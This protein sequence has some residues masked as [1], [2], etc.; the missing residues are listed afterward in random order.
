MRMCMHACTHT[1]AHT[2]MQ[3]HTHTHKQTHTHIHYLNVNEVIF[4]H[5][6]VGKKHVNYVPCLLNMCQV[7]EVLWNLDSSI[8]AVLCQ[9]LLSGAAADTATQPP[10]FGEMLDYTHDLHWDSHPWDVNCTVVCLCYICRWCEQEL[11]W[12]FFWPLLTY[13]QLLMNLSLSFKS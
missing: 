6:V 9:H 4:T 10:S 7:L 8:L 11:V 13:I 2:H 5:S 1:T 12:Q 3:R